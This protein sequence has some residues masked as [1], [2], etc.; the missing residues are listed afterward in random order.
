[1]VLVHQAFRVVAHVD[2][3]LGVPVDLILVDVG[4]GG[5]AAR[6]PRPRVL[7]DVVVANLR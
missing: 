7:A 1:M 2:A 5:A 3:R 6:D 4:V